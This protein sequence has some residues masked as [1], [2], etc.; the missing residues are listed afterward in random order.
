MIHLSFLLLNLQFR[1][2][3]ILFN[4]Y[5]I[6]SFYFPLFHLYYYFFFLY[7]YIWIS[8][9]FYTSISSLLRSSVVNV[10]FIINDSLIIFAPSTPILFTV[11]II[12]FIISVFLLYKFH[13]STDSVLSMVLQLK[14]LQFFSSSLRSSLSIFIVFNS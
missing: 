1:Y 7:F 9:S 10:V 11:H 5:L 4:F 2:L 14:L 3:F 8:I 13:H 6:F 12:L